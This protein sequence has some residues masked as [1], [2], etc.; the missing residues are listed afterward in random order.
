M[1]M[2]VI[3]TDA[4]ALSGPPQGEWSYEDWEALPDD[5]NRYEI[6]S[7]VLYMS[8]S[9]SYFHQFIIKRL[10]A[11]VGFPAEQQGLAEAAMGPVGLIM[12]YATP[13]QPDFVIVLAKNKHI[14]RDRR[15]RGV[16]DLIVEVLSPSN[17]AYDERIKLQAYAAAGVPEYGIVEPAKR[18]LRIFDWELPGR[19]QNPR[20]HGG[21][22]E[23][24][25]A[26]LPT[27]TFR[28]SALFE[29]SP[30]ETL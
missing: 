16:P 11:L 30:D 5:G 26:C 18:T 22:D 24:H 25:F 9:P 1:T 2:L 6:I 17:G 13:V 29:G 12:A 15:I 10:Y 7:G 20:E 28:T 23:A 3:P 8:T 4:P 14:I 19:Y 27:I 21:D